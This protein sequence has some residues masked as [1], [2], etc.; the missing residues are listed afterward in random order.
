MLPV[1]NVLRGT[2]P[3]LDEERILNTLSSDNVLL[4][5][6]VMRSLLSRVIIA[7]YDR[8]VER[9]FMCEVVD[10]C[11]L[12]GITVADLESA[13]RMCVVL[14]HLEPADG[15]SPDLGPM[16][17]AISALTDELRGRRKVLTEKFMLLVQCPTTQDKVS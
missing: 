7:C 11:T 14:S 5:P 10:L 15:T 12:M 13:G 6:N 16:S 3:K 17:D 9:E 1:T 8:K 4:T 2:D